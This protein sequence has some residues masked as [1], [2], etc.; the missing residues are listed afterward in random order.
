MFV[1]IWLPLQKAKMIDAQAFL[2]SFHAGIII[3]MTSISISSF[4]E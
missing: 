1:L 3:I 2:V 4:R